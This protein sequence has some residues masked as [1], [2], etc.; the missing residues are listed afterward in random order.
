MNTIDDLW[1]TQ[2]K[3]HT[4]SPSTYIC[5]NTLLDGICDMAAI[6][7]FWQAKHIYTIYWACIIL[8]KLRIQ[9]WCELF[10]RPFTAKPNNLFGT[11]AWDQFNCFWWVW[12][13][14]L[15]CILHCLQFTNPFRPSVYRAT[16][17]LTTNIDLG[18]FEYTDSHR[19]T[20]VCLPFDS[21]FNFS[22]EASVRIHSKWDFFEKK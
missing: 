20:A 2:N 3:T 16:G 8:P 6:C 14:I 7:G 15:I 10:V 9:G 17:K 5:S 19:H 11:W 21:L 1:N 22:N 13:N 12:T 18:C 4:K